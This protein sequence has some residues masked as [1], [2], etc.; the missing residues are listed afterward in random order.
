MSQ[1]DNNPYVYIKHGCVRLTMYGHLLNCLGRGDHH[2]PL[3]AYN[4]ALERNSGLVAERL[5]HTQ[6]SGMVSYPAYRLIYDWIA[7][8]RPISMIDPRQ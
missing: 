1:G 4:I 8:G 3:R 7:S 2:I 6:S 5:A